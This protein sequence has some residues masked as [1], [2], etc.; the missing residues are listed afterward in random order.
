MP[1]RLGIWYPEAALDVQDIVDPLSILN[2]NKIFSLDSN[3][4]DFHPTANYNFPSTLDGD[5]VVK[6]FNNVVIP[7]GVTVSTSNRCK[8]LYLHIKG[9]LTLNGAISM[10]AR[11]PDAAGKYVVIDHERKKIFF[12]ES[13]ENINTIKAVFKENQI[14]YP[15]G[16]LG[17]YKGANPGVNGACGSGGGSYA[18]Y[19]KGGNGTSFSGGAGA[20]GELQSNQSAD[21]KK[22]YSGYFIKA[23]NS[24]SI[25]QYNAHG[26]NNG[27][28]GGAACF[29][30]SGCLSGSGAGNPGG[31]SATTTSK[32]TSGTGGLIILIV[33][34]NILGNGSIIAQGSKGGN[35][36]NNKANVII[37]GA[38]GAGSGGGAIH[39][40]HKGSIASTIKYDIAGGDKGLSTTWK[41]GTTSTEYLS[42]AGGTGT[43]NIVKI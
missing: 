25:G 36:Y 10:T 16:G 19:A 6:T 37:F 1:R 32:G 23:A 9:N 8:G 38:G 31:I 7:A 14:I 22:V 21:N 27:G 41:N 3:L 33:E 4:G 28:Q 2:F 42:H 5:P 18:G 35:A 24:I 20:G 29:K 39:I 15:T 12:L 43:L 17:K 34:G 40:F 30:E 13:T 26:Q 11:G